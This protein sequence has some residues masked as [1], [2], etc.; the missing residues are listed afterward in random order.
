LDERGDMNQQHLTDDDMILHF[1]N[2]PDADPGAGD[3]MRDCAE[4]QARLQSLRR[5]LNSV[6]AIPVPER[7][8]LYGKEVW[9]IIRKRLDPNK[10]VVV[11]M[12]RWK[13][14]A[15]VA[16]MFVVGVSGYFIGRNSSVS[17]VKSRVP[18]T[19]ANDNFESGRQRVLLVALTNHFERSQMVLAELSNAEPGQAG[20]LDIRYE[21][22]EA[23]ELLDSNRLYRQAALQQGDTQAA[24][25][26]EDLERTLLEVA[27]SP[28]NVGEHEFE[29]LRRRIEDQGL[30][31]KVKVL[32]TRL[33]R[34]S[35]P[36][37]AGADNT[38]RGNKL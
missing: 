6:D 19:V 14:W 21:R 5:L 13:T 4:C 17:P 7:G 28:D 25:V 33:Q 35:V 38:K 24:V 31:F 16:A 27:H 36:G 23:S 22:E 10:P 37:P 8:E 30:V 20:K 15:A 3:H 1:Y 9:N 2:E 12:A 29:A 11:T 32:S 18:I 34:Q 26:L